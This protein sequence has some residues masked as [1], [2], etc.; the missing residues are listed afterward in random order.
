[1]EIKIKLTD[2]QIQQ[3]MT[4]VTQELL[5]GD[6]STEKEVEKK[7]VVR[8]TPDS[9]ESD[10]KDVRAGGGKKQISEEDLDNLNAM[11]DDGVSMLRACRELD[12][13]YNRIYEL[14]GRKKK[15]K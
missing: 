4:A 7:T 12:L 3:V 13:N 14:V 6:T 1:M 8:T 5:K 2:E 10:V 15:V 11:M 9:Q